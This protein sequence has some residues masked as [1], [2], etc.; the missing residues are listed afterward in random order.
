MKKIRSSHMV[1][2]VVSVIG[3][4][5]LSAASVVA[6]AEYP[7]RPITMIVGYNAGGGTDI[8]ARTLAPFIE[9]YL[10]DGA[11]VNV[12]NQPGA[13]GE[14]G[15]TRLAQANPDGYTIGFINTPNLIT[16][17]IQ[18][19]ARYS[20]DSFTPIANV[21]DD[22]GAFSV[23]PNSPF[24][25]LKELVEYAKENP[26]KVTYGTTGIGGDD[27]LA[28]LAF[29]RAVGVKLKHIPFSGTAEVRTAT[30]G[31]HIMM[32]NMNISESIAD[33]REG[34]LNILGQMAEE[35]W[36]EAPDVP[37]FKEQ[38]ANVVMGSMRGI[39][40]PAGLPEDIRTKLENA[41]EQAIND[42]DFMTRAKDQNLAL[43]FLNSEDF[44]LVLRRLHDDYSQIWEEQPWISQ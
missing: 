2:K 44:E 28:A 6:F 34:T 36:S 27:H 39:A 12:L 15:F 21:V 1:K 33:G 26:D 9:K 20:L 31:G 3:A 35:R 11:T 38:G 40:A 19:N 4:C 8:A 32:A 14:I 43:A 17:P 10:G 25:S 22:P 24:S 16:I 5:A 42:P 41:L 30:L 29:E 7:E 37:T 13:G 18:R 23:L